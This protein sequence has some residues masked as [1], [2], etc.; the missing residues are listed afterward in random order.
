[1]PLL[2]V[3]LNELGYYL[4]WVRKLTQNLKRLAKLVRKSL[5]RYY[6][7]VILMKSLIYTLYRVQWSK[8]RFCEILKYIYLK[9]SFSLYSY[10]SRSWSFIRYVEKK[11]WGS[12]NPENG[13][14]LA[15]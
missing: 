12:R 9:E 5:P 13:L 14:F 10:F 15:S 11:L 2:Q 1:M 8:K 6:S 3:M 4:T 7:K